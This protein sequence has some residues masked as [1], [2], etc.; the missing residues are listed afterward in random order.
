ME[1]CL[2]LED[3]VLSGCVQPGACVFAVITR[4]DEDLDPPSSELREAQR[5]TG[6]G[7]GAV[8]LM[9]LRQWMFVA[10]NNEQGYE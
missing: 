2:H 10:C 3:V 5:G 8:S 6:R 7:A 4:T 9:R 1:K